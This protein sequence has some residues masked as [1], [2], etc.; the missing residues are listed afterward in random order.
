VHGPRRRAFWGGN[1]R[2]V[3]VLGLQLFHR[4]AAP[5]YLLG[6]TSRKNY[7]E[8]A[9]GMFDLWLN[10]R[11]R[12]AYLAGLMGTIMNRKEKH[13]ICGQLFF[14]ALHCPTVGDAGIFSSTTLSCGV[15]IWLALCPRSS[16]VWQA[17]DGCRGGTAI[18]ALGF[19]FLTAGFA[20]AVM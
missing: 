4:M 13:I 16:R 8:P 1:T 11:Y 17:A 12:V 3:R 2:V 18:D 9:S 19:L 6:A 15:D 14:L 7:A 20:L 5:G 10:G